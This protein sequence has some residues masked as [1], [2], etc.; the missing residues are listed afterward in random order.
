MN[1]DPS[2]ALD[3]TEV[4]ADLIEPAFD[5]L[6]ASDIIKNLP[7]LGSAV[8]IARTVGAIRDR[9]FAAK[10]ARFLTELEDPSESEVD[11]MIRRLRADPELRDR[12]G[13]T[14][15]LV[16]DRLDELGKARMVGRAFR[17]YLRRRIDFVEF[18]R[19]CLVVNASFIDDLEAFVALTDPDGR[20]ADSLRR[21]LLGVGLYESSQTTID[22][23]GFSAINIGVS[24][25]GKLFRNVMRE[26]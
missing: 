1:D 26:R 23:G 13:S 7:V 6:L 22:L 14:V 8:R 19:V 20:G 21:S 16:L 5:A 24:E 2:P 12:V 17:A 10:I 18:R 11:Q 15:L 3:L 25:L 9:I 4:G